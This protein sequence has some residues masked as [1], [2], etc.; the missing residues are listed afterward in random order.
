MKF[1]YFELLKKSWQICW[2]YKILWIFGLFVPAGYSFPNFNFNYNF[3]SF[4]Q[5]ESSKNQSAE[6]VF[7]EIFRDTASVLKFLKAHLFWV[8]LIVISF[9]F[10]LLIFQ[11]LSWLSKPA[12]IKLVELEETDKKKP[13]LTEGFRWGEKFLFRYIV[14]GWL[15]WLPFLI[16]IILASAGLIISLFMFAK[17][18]ALALSFFFLFL[19]LILILALFSIPI[20]LVT[21]L[22]H[23]KIVIEEKGVLEAIKEGF[24]LFLKEW[25]K[26]V[27]I[28]LISLVV[29]VGFGFLLLIA[30]FPFLLLLLASGGAFAF[31]KAKTTS[32]LFLALLLSISIFLAFLLSLFTKAF[33][34]T[35]LTSYWTL[36][37]LEIIKSY[38]A[39]IQPSLPLETET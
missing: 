12:L 31:I 32:Y 34:G 17:N 2:K 35:F 29:S 16:L 33:S 15:L 37:Y 19:F 36:A 24:R 13:S 4:G 21:E 9:F 11:F 26:V 28:W 3:P 1:P 25:Q 39:Q 8:I 5:L 20:S 22:T 6:Q 10:L 14:S 18:F 23:R 7:S 38:S 30:G 27:V